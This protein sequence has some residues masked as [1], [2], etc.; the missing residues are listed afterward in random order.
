MA[1]LAAAL[2]G[3]FIQDL[4]VKVADNDEAGIV[5]TQAGPLRVFESLTQPQVKLIQVTYS[6]VLARAPEESVRFLAVPAAI[7]E[8][9]RRG[10]GRGI[11]LCANLGPN[12]V[13]VEGNPNPLADVRC[14]TGTGKTC[15]AA[16]EAGVTLIFGRTDWFVAQTISIVALADTFAEGTRVIPI[17]HTV[18]QGASSEDGDP[19]DNL[20]VPSVPVFVID[21]DSA[22]VIVI[23]VDPVGLT[24]DT[25]MIVAE[26][27][28]TP[29]RRR[30]RS[31]TP[32]RSS[33]RARPPAT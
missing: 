15:V 7:S 13:C 1:S 12:E 31:P 6:V 33:S 27:P 24:A 20:A 5:I 29:A 2:D 21:D 14:G 30:C 11:G 4:S 18:T 28:P 9:D 22:D 19:Y 32:S 17:L 10:G 25:N 26:D 23:P 8:R 16:N 3:V